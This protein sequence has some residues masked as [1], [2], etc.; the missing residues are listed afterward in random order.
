MIR[1]SLLLLLFSFAL[2]AQKKSDKKKNIPR[3]FEWVKKR[4]M[5]VSQFEI[6][7][8]QWVEFLQS[9]DVKDLATNTPQSNAINDKCVCQ[10]SLNGE[11]VI[12]DVNE[13]VFRDTTYYE[14]NESPPAGGTGKKGKKRKA[15]EN[16][17][18][19]PITGITIDQAQSFCNWLTDKYSRDD[20]Y[21][22]LELNFRLPTPQEMETLL[23]DTF[24][25]WKPEEDN[26]QA[27]QRGLNS[28]G[29]AIYNHYHNSWCDNNLNMKFRYGYKVPMQVGLFFPDMNGLY[30]LMGNVAELTSENG[31]AKGGSCIDPASECQPN[32]VKSYNGPQPWLGFRVVA[33]LSDFNSKYK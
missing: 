6:T 11:L 10:N 20:L 23:Q 29:C 15:V 17:S 7:A 3:G 31:I 30:D 12:K 26:Y 1:L 19:M 18:S 4:G 32:A 25:D 8:S 14:A 33:E 9:L 27:Y 24:A 2:E 5:V 22:E 13:T 21:A 16:C 28:H